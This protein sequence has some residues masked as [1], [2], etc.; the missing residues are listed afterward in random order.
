MLEL[1]NTI[2]QYYC[3]I[4]TYRP[5]VTGVSGGPDSL[6]L[7]DVLNRLGYPVI[8]GH[9]NHLIRPQGQLEASL[10]KKSAM[11]RGLIY[12]CEEF[13]VPSYAREQKLS[14]ETAAR[15]IRYRFL[16]KLAGEYRAQAVAVG[17]TADDQVETILLHLLRGSGMAGLRGM[18]YSA[19]PNQWSNTIPLVRP[20]LSIWRLEVLEYIN[21]HELQP[22]DDVSNLDISYLRNRV[23][24]ELIPLLETYN[25]GVRKSIWRTAEIV[26]DDMTVLD[27]MVDQAW[28]NC[29]D[30]I[31]ENYL[32]FR[33]NDFIKQ[34]KSVQRYLLIRGVRK[35]RPGSW[36]YDFSIIDRG[37]RFIENARSGSVS[38]LAQGLKLFA[39][40]DKLWLCGDEREL[41][42]WK[43]FPRLNHQQGVNISVPG[44][45]FLSSDWVLQAV[46][47]TLIEDEDHDEIFNN[48]D[49][50][51]TWVDADQLAHP[52]V[53]RGRV[54]GDIISPL[55][56]GESTI[57]ISDLMINLKIP[58]QARDFWP[59]V[60]DQQEVIWVPGMRMSH[61]VRVRA[62]TKQV[63]KFSA[64]S[65]P[66]E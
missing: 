43:Q 27:H 51:T 4:E 13:D 11:E 31:G 15:E 39:D 21:R 53:V 1:L 59:I 37:I 47:P 6:V 14:I 60:C 38:E 5:V 65:T 3:K 2:L 23:R 25:P 28:D 32:S 17:H 56:M 8:V 36:D 40:L 48:S 20:L 19:L 61:R 35:L 41:P 45:V 18:S 22:S 16:F 58:S 24:H 49:T 30:E 62:D 50:Y 42:I 7:L 26:K 63:V 10:V 9:L 44:R 54:P 12:V 57:K 46:G 66:R 55:G 34:A 33:R 29:L 52:L 64:L